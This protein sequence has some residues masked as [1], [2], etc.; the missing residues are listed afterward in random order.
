MIFDAFTRPD[1]I[2]VAYGDTEI[3][4]IPVADARKLAAR[5]V[6]AC[7]RADAAERARVMAERRAAAVV[8]FRQTWPD[9][10]DSPSATLG[11]LVVAD[12]LTERPYV[13]IVNEMRSC[14]VDHSEVLTVPPTWV[15]DSSRTKAHLWRGGAKS[16]CG[17]YKF[18]TRTTIDHD[19]APRCAKCA[20]LEA[21]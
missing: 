6:M 2:A 18:R 20:A 13:H 17:E 4:G 5:I 14:H 10:V 1:G 7:D 9:A 3:E 16:A 15:V 19:K 21:T 11:P 8:A 12:V